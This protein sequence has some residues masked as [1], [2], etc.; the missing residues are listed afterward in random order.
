[1]REAGIGHFP[2]HG[3][4]DATRVA[5]DERGRQP[6]LG[7]ADARLQPVREAGANLLQPGLRAF[8]RRRGG[9]QHGVA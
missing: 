1:M 7:A 8:G 3:L 4:G 6:A 5:G 2:A 9:D